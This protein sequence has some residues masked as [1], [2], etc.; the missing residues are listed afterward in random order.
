M[1]HSSAVGPLLARHCGWHLIWEEGPYMS[2]PLKALKI[3]TI[4]G[5]VLVR[6]GNQ[7]ADDTEARMNV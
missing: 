3:Q 7:F 2:R 1:V 4:V 5:V 6:Q